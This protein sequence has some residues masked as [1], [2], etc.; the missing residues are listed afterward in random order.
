MFK[1]KNLK[2]D[3]LRK[4]EIDFS[5]FECNDKLQIHQLKSV[6]STISEEELL[7]VFN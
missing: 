7:N 3:K 6:L 4:F 2:I 1:Y 5:H